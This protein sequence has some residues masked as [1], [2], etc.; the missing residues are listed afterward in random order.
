M[1]FSLSND[2]IVFLAL[3][4]LLLISASKWVSKIWPHCFLYFKKP[5]FHAFISSTWPTDEAACFSDTFKLFFFKF[6]LFF[7]NARAP[8]ETSNI[9]FPD[10]FKFIISLTI[11]F[12][13]IS[14]IRFL[15][16]L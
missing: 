9:S 15:S 3:M 2:S 11:L 10:L 12:K 4:A 6:R 8:E 5:F 7:P 14:F 13:I 1:L 16:S